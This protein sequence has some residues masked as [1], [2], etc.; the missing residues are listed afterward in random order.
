MA[1]IKRRD[2]GKVIKARREA[3]KLTQDQVAAVVG[4]TRPNVTLIEAGSHQPTLAFLR[5]FARLVKCK[6]DDILSEAA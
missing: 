5:Q 1:R 2:I 6:V 4:C 3:A